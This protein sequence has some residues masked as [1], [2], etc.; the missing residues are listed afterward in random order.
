MIGFLKHIANVGKVLGAVGVI[1]G[2]ALWMDGKFDKQAEDTA[3]VKQ[4]VEYN[5]IEIGLLSDR[6]ENFQDTLEKFES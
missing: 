1:G 2:S 6:Q 4:L 3:E 5:N